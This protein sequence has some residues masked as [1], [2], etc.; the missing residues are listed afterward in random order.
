MKKSKKKDSTVITQQNIEES[1]DKIL[2]KG[3]KFRYPFQYSKHRLV[4]ITVILSV[5]ALATFVF[6]GWFQ[7]YQAQSTSDIM[8]RFAKAFGLP[9]GKID[10]VN[11]RYGDYLMFYRSSIKSIERQQGA[12]D[13][14]ED[15]KRQ[16]EYYKRQALDSAIICDYAEAKLKEMGKSVKEE[17]VDAVVEEHKKIDGET[18][19]DEAFEGIIQDNFGLSIRDYR[20]MIRLSIARK[21][22]SIEVDERA[23]ALS[24]EISQKIQAGER[25]FNAISE[26]YRDNDIYSV[27]SIGEFVDTSNLDSG[28][29]AMAASL[30]NVG[31]VS[32]RFVSKNGEGY[33]FVKLTDRD[34]DRV[35][36]DSI[37]I[38]FTEY[39][40]MITRLREEGKIEEYIKVESNTDENN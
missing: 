3:K 18:R 13:D 25:D 20:T 29:A 6:I 40:N 31:D 37:T 24:D 21:N 11:V 30:A 26:A 32:E 5:I 17:E 33:V 9:V 36:Y 34:G 22:Y 38:R 39:S 14:S 2:A 8:Y 28:R 10:G 35:K 27:E 19:S 16:R 1:R 23:R 7:L 15:S 4:I 12:L